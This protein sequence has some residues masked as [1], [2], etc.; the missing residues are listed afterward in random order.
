[1]FVCCECCVLS[2]RGLC[3]ELITRPE[4]SYRLWCAVCDLET[5]KILVNEEEAKEWTRGAI[6]PRERERKKNK[7][8]VFLEDRRKYNLRIQKKNLLVNLP[9]EAETAITKLPAFDSVRVFYRNQL[10]ES[11]ET[12]HLRSKPYPKHN[13]DTKT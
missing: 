11:I 9:L 13:T 1:M 3:D 6:A 5:T 10:A 4:E 12:I 8:T 7:E 2:G